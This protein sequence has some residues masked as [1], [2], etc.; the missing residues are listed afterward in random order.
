MCLSS[1]LQATA[2]R[3]AES[4]DGPERELSSLAGLGG[5]VAYLRVMGLAGNCSVL[6][7]DRVVTYVLQ[8]GCDDRSARFVAGELRETPRRLLL[9]E[10]GW[11]SAREIVRNDLL[12][13]LHESA[14]VLLG[15]YLDQLVSPQDATALRDRLIR[16][17][18]LPETRNRA[19]RALHQLN[20]QFQQIN[21]IPPFPPTRRHP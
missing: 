9:C 20:A 7:L 1:Y 16:G 12:D 15:G 8:S 10:L 2:K 14:E 18:E 19:R 5:H 4:R 6:L 3:L 17:S 13:E 21:G 11:P